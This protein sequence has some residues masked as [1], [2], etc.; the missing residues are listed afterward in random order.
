MTDIFDADLMPCPFCGGAAEWEYTP[1]DE[2][3]RSGDDG[4]GWVEC[5]SC[6]VQMSGYDREDGEKRWNARKSPDTTQKKRA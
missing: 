3:S 2:E 6:H 4:T 1:W 5:Q